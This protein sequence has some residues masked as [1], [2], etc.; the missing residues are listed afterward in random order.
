MNILFEKMFSDPSVKKLI[1]CYNDDKGQE[2][3]YGLSGSQKHAMLSACYLQN[4][5]TIVIICNNG[6]AA[7]QWL[8]DL[9]ML[10]PEEAVITELPALDIM[11]VSAT[12][13]SMEL[14]A[15]RMEI[16][17]RLT[18]NMPLVVVATTAA[19]VQGNLSKADFDKYS[20]SLSI[21]DKMEIDTLLERLV[22]LG[23][24]N[25]DQVEHIGQF[26]MRGGIVDIFP[27]NAV[28]PFRIEFF[29]NSVESIRI[30][31]LETQRSVK[32]VGTVTVMPLAPSDEVGQK[33][34]FLSYLPENSVI[35]ID[36]PLRI[37]EEI[38]TMV[39]EIPEAKNNI[40]SWEDILAAA[41]KK[42]LIY[43][44]LMLQKIHIAKP[45]Q[46]ISAVVKEVA[47][48]QRQIELL[49]EE[50]KNWLVQKNDIIILM[51]D[52]QKAEY[53]HDILNQHKV[54][55][56]FSRTG[57][58]TQGLVCITIGTLSNGF[59][60]PGAHLVVVTEKD[61]MGR[62]KKRSA[63]R[64]INKGEKITHFRD[65]NIGDYVVHVN[66][67]IGKYLGVKTI[68]VNGIHRD[69]LHIK[70]GGDDKLFVPT[71]Q[72][73]LLQ[74]YIGSEGDIPR[75]SKM[76]GIAWNKAKAKAKEAVEKI[77]KDLVKL[78]AERKNGKGYAFSPDTPWQREF[79]DAFPYEE[80]PDQLAAV[81]DIKADMEKEKAMDRLL[82]GD[83]GFGKTEVAIRAAFKAAMDGKQVAVLVPT[84]V[85]AQQHFQTFS[86]RFEGFLPTVDVI[87]R[88]RTP[89]EQKITLEKV[90]MGEIDI[91]IGTHAI[92]NSKKVKFKDLG[93]LIVDEEQRF[94]VKQKEKIKAMSKNLDVL[95]LSATPI[96]RTLHMSLV[97]AR[98]M[99]IIETPPKERFSIQ[100][101][102]IENNDTILC[103]AIRREIRRG[104]QIYF[105]YNR[106]E[107]ID[108]MYLKLTDLLPEARIKVAH[109]QMPES[110]LEK[111]MMEFYEG[112]Y[113]ILLATSI[114]ENGLDIANANTIIIYDADKFGLSQLYQM[115]G[116]VGRSKSMAF[117]YFVYQRDK[118]LT[119]TAEKRLKAIKDF[120]ELGSGFKIAMRDLEIRGAGNL[121]GSQQHGHI[122]SVGF[123]MYCRLL[124][125]AIEQMRT[126][127]K[128]VE[129]VEPI[130]E[131]K[132][133]A[134]IDGGYISDAM[135]KM[136]IYQKIAALRNDEQIVSL[137]S[138]LED[139]FGSITEPVKNLL[140][141]ASIKNYARNLGIKSIVEKKDYIDF[142]LI[143][144]HNIK[145]EN[146][147][148]MRQYLGG[149]VKFIQSDNN[150][151]RLKLTAKTA[152]NP[153][154]IVMRTVKRLAGVKD[155]V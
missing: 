20:L 102:V 11:S 58:L 85:L 25:I 21:D 136:E 48:F 45:A 19:A 128:V 31:D 37:K 116:R 59:E 26:S 36:E 7:A 27:I 103:D 131:M 119:E 93:L 113:D 41:G 43:S 101:Y 12:A 56:N 50:L 81:K 74:K 97:G 140:K 66:H 8:S 92:L 89:K 64:H 83:V 6:E 87:C 77:A 135:H 75:L 33:T 9:N 29:D 34:V 82:C 38:L 22:S 16:L 3:I 138:E 88:F 118:V 151:I 121:L 149:M 53:I 141:I 109:G 79:E 51:N 124:E 130:I 39:K 18:Q 80:T 49:C 126:G 143:E 122:S 90:A 32:N 13:K 133:D 95:T 1:H 150:I 61:I 132:I 47:P 60:L 129:T 5:K 62:Q 76:D 68:T 114:I 152:A 84:T 134:Y 112:K 106:I 100:T 155:V 147:L 127:K 117:A 139:R 40:F 86:S 120:A 107:T 72:V 105:I 65:I 30:F 96:P 15:K 142:V 146:L 98:D 145:A 108:R 94:G 28:E 144:N 46:I 57:K 111:A 104:G 70:Y 71:D 78:Y 148:L 42:N 14:V 99:S 73:H 10:L 110:L 63:A 115:R 137:K 125:E 55:A 2:Y 154:N 17:G 54:P 52:E 4:P 44:S 69:Y 91:L 35:F 67:G 153:V 123:E 23:Y 24:E